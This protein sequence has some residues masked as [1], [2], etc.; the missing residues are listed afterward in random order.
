[1]HEYN[2]RV[3]ATLGVWFATAA[4][5]IFGVFR[6]N[7]T[8]EIAGVFWMVVAL[9]ICGAAGGSTAAIWSKAR[10]TNKRLTTEGSHKS[11]SSEAIRKDPRD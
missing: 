9:A 10:E 4:I 3:V 2:A 6:M 5:F 1:M 11:Y 8:G 7:W